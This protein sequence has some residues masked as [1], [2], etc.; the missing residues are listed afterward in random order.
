MIKNYLQG[1]VEVSVFSISLSASH[2]TCFIYKLHFQENQ[3]QQI[4]WFDSNYHERHLCCFAS[5]SSVIYGIDQCVFLDVETFSNI[6]A[7]IHF[8]S[9][10]I[11][12]EYI[13]SLHS[14]KQIFIKLLI[15]KLFPFIKNINVHW[16]KFIDSYGM[17]WTHIGDISFMQ[18]FWCFYYVFATSRP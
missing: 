4:T 2:S 14:Y 6:F 18:I 7:I 8:W 5:W 13:F 11:F 17:H 9:Y 1:I 12:R 3:F 16:W 15:E 10:N